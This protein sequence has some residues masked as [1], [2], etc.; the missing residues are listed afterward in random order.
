MPSAATREKERGVVL[1]T[2]LLLLS[3]LTALGATAVLQGTVDLRI[4]GNHLAGL[5]A[6]Y[7][8]EAGASVAAAIFLRDPCAFPERR[9]A[10]RLGLPTTRPAKPNL[11]EKAAYWCP[12]ITYDPADPPEWADIRCQGTAIDTDLSLIHI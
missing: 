8:A 2:V 10:Q 6:R 12:S 11:E 1:V 3:V 7:A 9:T 4:C 5:Q